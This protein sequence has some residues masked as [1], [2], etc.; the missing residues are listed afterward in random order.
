MTLALTDAQ[1]VAALANGDQLAQSRAVRSLLAQI[2]PSIQHY[3]GANNGTPEDGITIANEAV[4]VLWEALISGKFVLHAEV[5]LSTW[6][7]RVGMN[8]WLKE[9]RRR[10]GFSDNLGEGGG[11]QLMD[12]TTPLD[13]ITALEEHQLVSA[14]MQR[15][16]RA[17]KKLG[18][19]CQQLFQADLEARG[20]AM[21]MTELGMTHIGGVKVKR[22]RCKAKWIELYHQEGGRSAHG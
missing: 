22:H 7:H 1:I 15:A 6:C 11:I 16:W 3:V 17:F 21:I 14:E 12:P 8:L 13:L 20:E 2:R 18:A 9:L 4:V 19:G 10:K 5:K